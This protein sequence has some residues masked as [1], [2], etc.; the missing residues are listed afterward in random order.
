V[1]I[2]CDTP[3]PTRTC[4]CIYYRASLRVSA[5]PVPLLR[6]V[7]E[8][9]NLVGVVHMGL[10]ATL[11]VTSLDSTQSFEVQIDEPWLR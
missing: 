3:V 6:L 5:K 2:G 10:H 1:S 4:I 11:S 8:P 9:I 7:N